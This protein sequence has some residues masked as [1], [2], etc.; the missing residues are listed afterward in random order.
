MALLLS[1]RRNGGG[2]RTRL[3]VR[4]GATSEADDSVAIDD[5]EV[6]PR[7]GAPLR[8]RFAPPRPPV[9]TLPAGGQAR[10]HW[11]SPG[12]LDWG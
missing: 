11:I 9:H 3:R 2:T 12:T 10:S 8:R 7:E 4:K 1:P 5:V 6:P